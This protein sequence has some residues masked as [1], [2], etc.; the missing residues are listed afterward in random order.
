MENALLYTFSTIAQTLGG[1]LALIGAFVL[2]R[3]QNLTSEIEL[4]SGIARTHV[5]PQISEI[6]EAYIQGNHQ[7]VLLLT[8]NTHQ[9]EPNA[10]LR[11]A[12]VKFDVLSRQRT[13]LVSSFTASAFASI[14]LM[15]GSTVILASTSFVLKQFNPVPILIAGVFLFA[16]V[17]LMF[18]RLML[19]QLR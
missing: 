13:N 6:T 4:L 1:L 9:G 5:R 18:A 19:I 3:H 11:S 15:A 12:W 14:F 17:L 2:Y 7:Q 10:E 8:K 16:C